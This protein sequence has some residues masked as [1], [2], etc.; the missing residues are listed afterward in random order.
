METMKKVYHKVFKRNF[1]NEIVLY[2]RTNG[3]FLIINDRNYYSFFVVSNN[4]SQSFDLSQRFLNKKIKFD[5]SFPDTIALEYN[6]DA[7][8]TKYLCEA[9]LKEIIISLR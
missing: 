9:Y 7:E 5:T 4:Y 1:G 3:Y 2:K 8:E 6:F